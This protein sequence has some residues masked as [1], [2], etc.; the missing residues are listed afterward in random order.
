MRRRGCW[1]R[2][3]G[4]C[5]CWRSSGSCSRGRLRDQAPDSSCSNAGFSRGKWPAR[6]NQIEDA[7][8]FAL[9]RNRYSVVLQRSSTRAFSCR[10]RRERG[11]VRDRNARC[12][13]RRAAEKS[14]G[15]GSGVG[16]NASSRT[17]GG[18]GDG[19]AGL[20]TFS[21]RATRLR[22]GGSSNGVDP[23]REAQTA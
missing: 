10:I 7:G 20:Y 16:C 4:R 22:I 19:T 15:A 2:R 5:R 21:H 3:A 9:F 18:L 8:D 1:G 23:D 6:Y 13:S 11:Y 17:S 14:A 12:A